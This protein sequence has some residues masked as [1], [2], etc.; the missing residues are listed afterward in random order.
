MNRITVFMEKYNIH[1]LCCI[2][3]ISQLCLLL[4]YGVITDLEAAKYINQ[5]QIFLATGKYS[6]NNFLFY[7]VEI[8]F[9]T[10]CLKLKLSYVLIIIVQ[11]IFN[12]ISIVCFYKLVN[13]ISNNITIS[14]LSTLYFLIFI[15]YHLYN[16]F[17]FTESLFFSFSI[18]Y[19]YF[20]FSRKRLTIKNIFL[21]LL[22]LSILYL[23]R[24]TGIFFIPSTFIFLFVK[25]YSKNSFKIIGIAGFTALVFLYY[26]FNYSLSSGGEF[27]F[28]LPYLNETIICGVQTIKEPHIIIIP[29]EKNSI[30]GLF[31]I[32]T[33]HF[34]LF[35]KLAVQRLNA[36]FGISRSYYSVFHNIFASSY[37]YLIYIIIIAAIKKLF[38]SN[39]AEVWFLICNISLM[40][41]TV[42][43]C[44]DEWANRFILSVL[45]FFLLL[46]VISISNY[47]KPY[48]G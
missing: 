33:H 17:L 35:A 4:H 8:L 30:G 6:S 41:L 3:V 1:F 43:L 16:T 39:K 44:C 18:I 23:T 10:L 32:I 29:V 13:K 12:G 38:K 34:N 19:T 15:Y 11:I 47:R 48:N 7:S 21:M 9:I 20:L 45:P 27:D 46:A 5:A 2:W 22:F 42:M 28:L 14:F 26:L 37:F 36:F 25:F 31:Y 24:P 40:A